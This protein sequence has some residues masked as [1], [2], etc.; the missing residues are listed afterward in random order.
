MSRPAPSTRVV[1]VVGLLVA[2]VLAGVVSLYA[3]RSPDGLNRVARDQGFAQTERPHAADG[4]PLAGYRTR[5]VA[6]VGLSEAL[7]RVVG[8]GVVLAL[9]SGLVL[10]VRR[11]G[12][13]AS[14]DDEPAG[15]AG[16]RG[17]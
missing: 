13:R 1:V 16:P 7:S 10:V 12:G 15:V 8:A 5:G 14:E 4:S 17:D 3:S 2:L 11:R 6:D 9:A